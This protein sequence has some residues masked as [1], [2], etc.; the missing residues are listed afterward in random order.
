MP[1]VTL[2]PDRACP[3]SHNCYRSQNSGTRPDGL[4]QSWFASTP[5]MLNNTCDAYW[6]LN[7]YDGGTVPQP[8]GSRP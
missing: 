7:L 2:C 6:P 4:R 5:R 8:A 3:L 1:D